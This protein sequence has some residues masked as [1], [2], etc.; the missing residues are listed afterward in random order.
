MPEP[1][2]T[3]PRPSLPKLTVPAKITV[4]IV[5]DDPVARRLHD[6]LVTAQPGFT[7]IGNAD[8]LRIARAML[9]GLRPDL[10]LLD[11]HLPDGQG[12]DLL[13][14]LPSGTDCI[15]ITAA[16]DL[17]H[18]MTALSHGA[19]DYLVKPVEPS[20][21]AVALGRAKDRAALRRRSETGQLG[22]AQLDALFGVVGSALPSGFDQST[23]GRVRAAVTAGEGVTAQEVADAA[24]MSRVTAWRYLELLCERG[25]LRLGR[26][27][28]QV[29][30]PAKRYQRV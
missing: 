10:L 5:E 11:V 8:T 30:R 16:S 1:K 20:R 18:V 15:L 17:E 14:L 22:Q 3:P 9:L 2:S 6:Q 24:G 29:G 12:L 28:R 21:L 26:A 13:P 25:E 23:L 7:V 4:L 27:E 19:A